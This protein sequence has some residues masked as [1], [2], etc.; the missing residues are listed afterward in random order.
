M[1]N[2]NIYDY[3][4]STDNDIKG[5][6]KYNNKNYIIPKK[7]NTPAINIEG[8]DPK[9]LFTYDWEDHTVNMFMTDTNSDIM[10]MNRFVLDPETFINNPISWFKR[11]YDEYN[12]INTK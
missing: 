8:V 10:L 12:K 5:S 11:V 4:Y 7:G 1:Q 9:Y 3:L 2:F 6:I